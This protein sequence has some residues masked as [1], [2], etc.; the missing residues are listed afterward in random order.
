MTR[1]STA[2]RS[3]IARA[4]S[5][6]LKAPAAIAESAASKP[7][8]VNA[9]AVRVTRNGVPRAARRR[10]RAYLRRTDAFAIT[11]RE[12]STARPMLQA[13]GCARERRANRR[14]SRDRVELVTERQID[15]VARGRARAC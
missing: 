12:G 3:P 4:G 13:A 5:G 15:A 11:V 1:M 2:V 10:P 7:A 6:Q 8:A 9:R 14:A